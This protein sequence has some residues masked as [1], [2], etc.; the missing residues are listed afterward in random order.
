ML[1]VDPEVFNGV[2]VR[3]LCWP[4]NDNDVVVLEPSCCKSRGMFWVVV[5]LKVPLSFL[6]SQLFKTLHHSLIQNLTI[7]H[8]IHLPLNLHKLFHTIP[9][10]A[11]PYHKI[12]PSSMLDSQCCSA[13]RY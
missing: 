8:L 5:L 10:H 12:V 3:G 11:S 2:K 9:A 6:H 13:I 7:L 4:M 1:D